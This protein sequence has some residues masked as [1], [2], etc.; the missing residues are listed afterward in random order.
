M[1][2]LRWSLLAG[3]L[4]CLCA[5]GGGGGGNP[6]PP[7]TPP[8]SKATGLAY[9]DPAGSGFRLVKDA[10]STSAR[11]VLRLVGPAG[12]TGRGVSFSLSVDPAQADL[13][14]VNDGDAEYVQN[15]EVFLLGNAP[16]LLKGLR[17]NGTLSVTA[18][19][20]GSGSARPLDGTLLKVAIQFKASANLVAGASIPITLTEGQYL[21]ASGGPVTMTL[22]AGAL[23][24]Q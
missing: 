22:S 7:P 6:A 20:K 21:P 14:K 15:G 13:V 4:G 5:C 11:I 9:S 17:Q 18:A 3:L 24:A 19:Q 23:T 16:Q 2:T 10:S 12:A 1:R 8:A